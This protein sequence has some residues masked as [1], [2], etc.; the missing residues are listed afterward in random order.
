VIYSI[1]AGSPE[2]N[3]DQGLIRVIANLTDPCAAHWLGTQGPPT[4][5]DY[6]TPQGP[7]TILRLEGDTI[8]YSNVSGGSGRFNFVTGHFLPLPAGKHSVERSCPWPTL[9]A[10]NIAR[11]R[12]AGPSFHGNNLVNVTG[13]TASTG[14]IYWV[15]AGAPDEHPDQGLIRVKVLLA[16]PCASG[17]LGTQAPPTTDYFAPKGPLTITEVEGDTIL[18]SIAGGGSGRFNFVTG[19]FLP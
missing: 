14:N 4:L 1:W 16:D 2:D 3:P 13:A 15:W 9:D 19:Q 5:T 11:F 7:L 12:G 18:Y 6:L 17:L 8:I 10:S